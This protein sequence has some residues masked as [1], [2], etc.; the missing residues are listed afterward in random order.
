MNE[1][2]DAVIPT[3]E[4]ARMTNAEGA[5]TVGKAKGKVIATPSASAVP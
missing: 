1:K 5:F 3:E 4:R 2:G